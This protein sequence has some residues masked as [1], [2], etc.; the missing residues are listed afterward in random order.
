LEQGKKMTEFKTAFI[1]AGNIAKAILGGYKAA[2]PS[3][4]IHATDA[5]PGQ[6]EQLPA[7][8]TSGID[9]V[10]A[11]NNADVIMLCV[12]PN[13]MQEIC[14]E[15]APKASQKLFVSVAAGITTEHLHNWL[16]A[17][18]AIIRCMPNTPAL[19]GEGMTGLYAGP[20]VSAE[21]RSVAEQL[22]NCV[23][24]TIWFD[25]ETELDTVTAVSGS[26]PAYY[27]LLIEAMQEAAISMGL[28]PEV[29]RKLVLQTAQG[30]SKMA[31]TSELDAATLRQ[32]V[33]SPGGTTA[34]ALETFENQNF[35]EIVNSALKAAERRSKELSQE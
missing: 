24:E 10:A 19:V 5:F 8:V 23:G 20:D 4:D 34:A 7:G 13:M 11:V 32:N 6:L 15:L 27:F 12:K 2:N 9:N 30:A 31:A 21:Q 3:A 25:S 29:A 22:L 17:E 1:G 28:A 14:L 33:T 35:R 18:A 26:G 16:G